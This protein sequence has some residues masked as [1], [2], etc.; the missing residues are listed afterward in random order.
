MWY[1]LKIEDDTFSVRNV[2]STNYQRFAFISKHC[3]SQERIK[4]ENISRS[5]AIKQYPE[6]QGICVAHEIVKIGEIKT[7]SNI[8]I[9]TGKVESYICQSM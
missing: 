3:N 6:L 4:Y 2:Q 5:N 9:N 7:F 8:I 1:F